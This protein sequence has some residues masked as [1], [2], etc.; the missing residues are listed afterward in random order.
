MWRLVISSYFYLN[1]QVR[2]CMFQPCNIMTDAVLSS[3][4]RKQMPMLILSLEGS[5]LVTVV[6]STAFNEERLLK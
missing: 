1:L 5:A 6:K 2:K 4:I 3:V